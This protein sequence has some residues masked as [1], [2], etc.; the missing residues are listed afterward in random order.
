MSASN[1]INHFVIL[2]QVSLTEIQFHRMDIS[3]L[4]E[5]VKQKTYPPGLLFTAE[6]SAG[7]R[8]RLSCKVTIKGATTVAD[9]E[10]FFNIIVA[11][12]PYQH[13]CKLQT[14]S[15]IASCTCKRPQPF[16]KHQWICMLLMLSPLNSAQRRRIKMSRT[17]IS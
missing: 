2:I 1:I 13:N 14:M 17:S 11:P 6:C 5:R 9:N 4:M 10:V 8:K 15:I 16:S 7:A 3:D 12:F